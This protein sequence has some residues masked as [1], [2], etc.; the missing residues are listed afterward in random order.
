MALHY[1]WSGG[2]RMVVEALP[3]GRRQI[4]LGHA[5]GSERAAGTRFDSAE[6]LLARGDRG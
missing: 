5:S 1:G 2:H 4:Q 6:M 3:E